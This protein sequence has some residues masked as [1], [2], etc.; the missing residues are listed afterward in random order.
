MQ[1]EAM[2]FEGGAVRAALRDCANDE[3]RVSSRG[4]G[5]SGHGYNSL[6][7]PAGGR[8]KSQQIDFHHPR[9]RLLMAPWAP[10]APSVSRAVGG[11]GV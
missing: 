9:F 6:L 3:V 4:V 10:R 7:K 11:H 5:R 1:L 8:A 2:G